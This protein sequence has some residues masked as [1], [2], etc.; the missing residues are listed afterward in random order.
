MP[1][2][3]PLLSIFQGTPT[4]A[5]WRAT[6]AAGWQLQERR[7]LLPGLPGPVCSLTA[8]PGGARVLV[9]T[10]RPISQWVAVAEPE[11]AQSELR[12]GVLQRGLTA[13]R[14]PP[15]PVLL[16]S[17]AAWRAAA[18]GSPPNGV[19]QL[20]AAPPSPPG[21]VTRLDGA[22][23]L[24]DIR[25]GDHTT[26]PFLAPPAPPEAPAPAPAPAPESH[27][28]ARPSFMSMA[29]TV[30]AAAAV[31]APAARVPP[32]E[33]PPFLA[34]PQPGAGPAIPA[35]FMLQQPQTKQMPLAEGLQLLPGGTAGAALPP[36]PHEPAAPL[37]A[38][39][40]APSGTDGGA[41]EDGHAALL[42][43]DNGSGSASPA[44]SPGHSAGS[45]REHAVPLGFA[46]DLAQV[47]AGTA[48]LARRC[49]AAAS[50][51]GCRRC[52]A[53]RPR[54]LHAPPDMCRA[55]SAGC[56]QA[57]GGLAV[58]AS[59]RA[60]PAL[61]L[62]RLGRGGLR[63]VAAM[64]LERPAGVPDSCTVR[65]RGLAVL[66]DGDATAAAA[67]A[68]GLGGTTHLTCWVLLSA[69]QLGAAAP[70]LSAALSSR[71]YGSAR[72]QL[73]L[74]RYRLAVPAPPV[75]AAAAASG[76][77]DGEA[78]RAQTWAGPSTRHLLAGIAAAAHAA[79]ALQPAG[80]PTPPPAAATAL[81]PLPPP[82]LPLSIAA[83]APAVAAGAMPE[84]GGTVD[85]VLTLQRAVADFRREVTARL[86]DLDTGLAKLLTALQAP[87]A[88]GASD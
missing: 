14:H 46:P 22:T 80:P 74:C 20:A 12:P 72:Q 87:G 21:W 86:D 49:P 3:L 66:P 65:I 7:Q 85:T 79:H 77:A 69:T 54:C 23:G 84:P 73:W 18:R 70:F 19:A 6:P 16:P 37:A 1:S 78:A 11:E 63:Q 10:E 29:P 62:C 56:S 31:A 32:P 81:P 30:A 82:K 68:A 33:S 39:A 58:V 34:A 61:A 60:A 41:P 83:A 36:P 67:A 53:L 25:P 55:C 76:S 9:T 71:I 64:P 24:E 13:A 28:V 57:A 51:T 48:Q 4:F 59:S 5:L 45:P 26:N 8:V 52:R 38:A 43:L 15:P 88:G 27:L 75:P 17:S 42:W 40:A 35:I 47:G 50:G 2:R 44:G